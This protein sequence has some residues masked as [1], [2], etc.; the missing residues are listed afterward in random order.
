MEQEANL[1][2]LCHGHNKREESFLSPRASLSLL[3]DEQ[4]SVLG[5]LVRHPKEVLKSEY[6]GLTLKINLLMISGIYL[7]HAVHR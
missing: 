3:V 1:P 7:V 6:L 2:L 5:S 4:L